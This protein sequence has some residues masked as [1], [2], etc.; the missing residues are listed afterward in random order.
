[1]NDRR[2]VGWIVRTFVVLAAACSPWVI[3]QAVCWL[4]DAPGL[5]ALSDAG[6]GF[7]TRTVWRLR[8]IEAESLG[9]VG[10]GCGLLAA[11]IPSHFVRYTW[12][13]LRFR[14]RLWVSVGGVAGALA[15]FASVLVTP[16]YRSTVSLREVCPHGY[17]ASRFGTC[18][19]PCPYSRPSSEELYFR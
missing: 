13:L 17:T 4:D 11:W 8:L 2:Y 1:M 15:L 19:P 5:L 12:Y 6:F 16:L 10:L 7:V 9:L 18:A 3:Q 14:W